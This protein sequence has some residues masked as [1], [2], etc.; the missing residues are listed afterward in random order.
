MVR[1]MS[2]DVRCQDG[3]TLFLPPCSEDAKANIGEP[4]V[5]AEHI[6][7]QYPIGTLAW[8]A[9]MGK[10]FRY[11]K[12]GTGMGGLTTLKV[13]GNR[14]PTSSTYADRDGF[15][16]NVA[17]AH[18]AGVTEVTFTDTVDRVK[19][20]FEGAHMIIFDAARAV[21]YEQSYIISGPLAAT[22]DPWSTTVTLH[23]PKKYA[24][25]ANDGVEIWRN[26]YSN[27]IEHD[28]AVAETYYQTMMGVAMI[29]ITSGYYFWLQTSGPCFITPNGWS[30]LCPG[31]AANTRRVWVQQGGGII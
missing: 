28:N 25:L 23:K 9:G 26:P 3:V 14:P 22:T 24:I 19:N 13:N 21:C 17:T 7:A 2:H 4:D 1:I 29:P 11:S 27:I 12:A 8:F 18:A 16:G 10:K 6:V 31:Y 20:Y 5:Y 30:T 15:Y